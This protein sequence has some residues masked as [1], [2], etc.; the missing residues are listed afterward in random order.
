MDKIKDIVSFLNPGQVC[1]IAADQPQPIY[2]VAKKVQCHWLEKY[3]EEQFLIMFGSLHIEMTALRSV[4]SLVQYSG[5][6]GA[7][8]EAGMSSPGTA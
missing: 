7:L 3:G 5:W 1:I 8:V 4:V 6:M 2:A